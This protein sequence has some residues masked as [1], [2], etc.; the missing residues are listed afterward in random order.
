MKPS[1]AKDAKDAEEEAKAQSM[2]EKLPEGFFDDPKQDAKVRIEPQ[3]MYLF[4]YFLIFSLFP[5]T[6]LLGGNLNP[7]T[8]F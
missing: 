4:F 2:A 7:H 5:K 1:A 3:N 6:P 8:S